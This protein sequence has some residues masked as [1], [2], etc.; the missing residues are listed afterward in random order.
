[1]TELEIYKRL[2]EKISQYGIKPT[3]KLNAKE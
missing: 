3:E 2:S 1:M